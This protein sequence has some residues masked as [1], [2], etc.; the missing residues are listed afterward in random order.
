MLHLN[1]IKLKADQF[2]LK[3]KEKVKNAREEADAQTFENDFF[4]IFGVSR[5]KIAVFEQ[6]VKLNDGSLGYIDLLWKGY[7][8]IE[9]KRPG[10]NLNQA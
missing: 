8:L 10:K 4:E 3:W 9:M 2:V 7:I 1:E 6:K 5:N